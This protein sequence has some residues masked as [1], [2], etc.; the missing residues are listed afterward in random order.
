MFVLSR[1]T[2]N[3]MTPPWEVYFGPG[4]LN[5]HWSVVRVVCHWRLAQLAHTVSDCSGLDTWQGS[6][7]AA[8]L[9]PVRPVCCGRPADTHFLPLPLPAPPTRALF[10]RPNGERAA[11]GVTRAAGVCSLWE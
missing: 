5:Y 8:T 3:V 6:V 10:A 4:Y 1:E 2:G 7:G 11:N 9:Q